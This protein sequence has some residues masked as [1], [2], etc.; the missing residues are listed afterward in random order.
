M[1]QL[2]T[3]E[4][5][6]LADLVNNCH[7]VLEDNPEFAIVYMTEMKALLDTLNEGNEALCTQAQNLVF[8]YFLREEVQ[9]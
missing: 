8:D 7:S 2:V 5:I 4:A 6:K 1:S 3:S 9:S